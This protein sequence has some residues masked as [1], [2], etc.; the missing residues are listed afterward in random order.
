MTDRPTEPSRL[1]H[2]DH[3]LLRSIAEDVADIKADLRGRPGSPN[4][5]LIA[6][7]EA[8]EVWQR[9]HEKQHVRDGFFTR[10]AL[11]A[12]VVAF[13]AQIG[14]MIFGGYFSGHQ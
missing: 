2:I 3:E 10:T 12:A 1:T 5:G 8:S 13:V 9:N 6:R 7:Q 4:A 11:G 14:R